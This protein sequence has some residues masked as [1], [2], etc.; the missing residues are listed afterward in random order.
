[1]F[2]MHEKDS[3]VLIELSLYLQKPPAEAYG[4]LP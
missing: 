1:M 2:H 4:G 3:V